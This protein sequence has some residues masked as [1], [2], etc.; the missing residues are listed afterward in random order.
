MELKVECILG[1]ICYDDVE[2]SKLKGLISQ[3]Q[4]EVVSDFINR[5]LLGILSH[6]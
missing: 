2:S 3:Q 5:T 6:I 1:L 4:R